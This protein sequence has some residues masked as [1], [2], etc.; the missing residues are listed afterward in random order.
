MNKIQVTYYNLTKESFMLAMKDTWNSADF[1]E[2]SRLDREIKAIEIQYKDIELVIYNPSDRKQ[3]LIFKIAEAEIAIEEMRL[4]G[5]KTL[6][7]EQY[8]E[9]LN[10]QLKEIDA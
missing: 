6:V 9:K 3:H 7:V 8:L 4:Q 5:L 10:K 1:Q 2:D